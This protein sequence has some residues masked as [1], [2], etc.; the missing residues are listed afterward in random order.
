MSVSVCVHHHLRRTI[1]NGASCKQSQKIRCRS[2]H[3]LTVQRSSIGPGVSQQQT[4]CL[5]GHMRTNVCLCWRRRSCRSVRKEKETCRKATAPESRI[6]RTSRIS[7]ISSSACFVSCYIFQKRADL[8]PFSSVADGINAH[9]KL[10][11]RRPD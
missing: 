4:C 1:S 3:L 11:M 8:K 10:I 9:G 6:S 7:R 2:E 5:M